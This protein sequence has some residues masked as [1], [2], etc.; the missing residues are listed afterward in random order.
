V[1]SKS[2]G[3][4]KT[5]AGQLIRR[6]D[7]GKLDKLRFIENHLRSV[8]Q[9]DQIT[10]IV[11]GYLTLRKG[12]CVIRN[13]ASVYW[14]GPFVRVKPGTHGVVEGM[15]RDG[16]YIVKWELLGSHR[17]RYFAPGPVML[18]VKGH[19]DFCELT[20]TGNLVYGERMIA[21]K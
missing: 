21:L 15:D 10:K 12:Q 11:S 14:R 9:I 19:H 16:D 17:F 2:G 6:T 18:E 13:L 1:K 3:D 20:P 7:T 8:L 5:N 4:R